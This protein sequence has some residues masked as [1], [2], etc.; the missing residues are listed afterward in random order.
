MMLYETLWRNRLPDAFVALLT[1]CCA[2]TASGQSSIP[3]VKPTIK[4]QTPLAVANEEVSVPQTAVFAAGCFWSV[5]TDFERA[6]GVIDI[7]SGYTGGRSKSPTYKTYS[8]GGHREAVLITYDPKAITYAGLIEFL[9]KH[10]N[11]IDRGGSFVDRGS[12]YTAAIY[13]ANDDEKKIAQDI[14]KKF[15]AMKVFRTAITVPLIKRSTFYPAEVYH[16]DYHSKNPGGY[17]DYRATCGRDTFILK[18]WGAKADFLSLPSSFPPIDLT[19]TNSEE[20]EKNAALLKPWVDFKK[21]PA[22]TLKKKLNKLQF[23]VTQEEFTEKAFESPLCNEKAP[24]IYVDV[25]SG[26]PL[27]SSRDKVEAKDSWPSFSRPIIS[28]AVLVYRVGTRLETY[29]EVRSPRAESHLGRLLVVD[30]KAIEQS[31]KRF[32]INGAALR[33]ISL[34]KMAEEGYGEFLPFVKAAAKQED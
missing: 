10:S 5:E 28:S 13:Y 27:F 8:G 14:I 17:S 25:V 21:P 12:N 23:Q 22:A 1:L 2:L 18:H 9:L 15:D 4:S 33:F 3:G 24:G 6:P 19:P 26:E 20:T 16:Q 30:P 34:D 7:V 32:S 29:I 11:P 31:E